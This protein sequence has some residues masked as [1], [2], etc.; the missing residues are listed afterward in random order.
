MATP[1]VFLTY[2]G[3]IFVVIDNI[4]IKRYDTRASAMWQTLSSEFGGYAGFL[5]AEALTWAT[6]GDAWL[7]GQNKAI[8]EANAGA[9]EEEAAEETPAEEQPA[10]GEVEGEGETPAEGEEATEDVATL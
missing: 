3:L 5:G 9:S 4:H 10:E 6:Y 1:A 2:A 7:H 8:A